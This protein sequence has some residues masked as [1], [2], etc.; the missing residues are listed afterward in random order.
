MRDTES[1]FKNLKE[2]MSVKLDQ[3]GHK[4]G[5]KNIEFM[6]I[7]WLAKRELREIF[8]AIDKV[9]DCEY[10]Y[11]QDKTILKK[12]LFSYALAELMYEFADLANFAAFG[13]DNCKKMMESLDG[14][15]TGE[16]S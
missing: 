13:I 15:K 7:A 16:E 4:G 5:W 2:A 10:D 6:E 12:E 11:Q 9:E 1:L 3:N 14:D 8:Y